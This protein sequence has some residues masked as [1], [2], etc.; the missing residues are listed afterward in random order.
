MR[1]TLARFAAIADAVSRAAPDG[2][3]SAAQ[4]RDRTDIGRTR[5]I[6]ILE[7]L[8]R[9]GITQRIGDVRALRKDF[10]PILGAATQQP[11]TPAAAQPASRLA[12]ATRARPKANARPGARSGHRNFKL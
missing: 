1:G 8:D 11:A 10:V 4:V 7:C 12:P 2:R 9:L 3:F 6:E 5:A